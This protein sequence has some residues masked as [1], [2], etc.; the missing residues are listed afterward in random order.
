MVSLHAREVF[1]GSLG[2]LHQDG[3]YQGTDRCAVEER[4]EEDPGVSEELSGQSLATMCQECE[5]CKRTEGQLA[6]SDNIV[7]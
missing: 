1:R 7:S 2:V 3:P 4:N 5:N 6:E